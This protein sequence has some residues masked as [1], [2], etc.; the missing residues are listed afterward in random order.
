MPPQSSCARTSPLKKV[1]RLPTAT[2][3]CAG[4]TPVVVIV[5]VGGAAGGAAVGGLGALGVGTAP[6]PEL[7]AASIKLATSSVFFTYTN[8]V[9]S[10]AGDQ[11]ITVRQPLRH[12]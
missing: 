10:G 11:R 7:H 1:T 9:R 3:T 8:P 6:E 12:H 5:I 2:V 4:D